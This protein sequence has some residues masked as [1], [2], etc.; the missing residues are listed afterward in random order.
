MPEHTPPKQGPA[1]EDVSMDRNTIKQDFAQRLYKE[2]TNKGWTQAQLARYSGLNR[3]AISTYIRARSL[4]T[5]LSLSKIA[6]TLGCSPKDLLPSH[7]EVVVENPKK[8]RSARLEITEIEGEE[9][10]MHLRC[11]L[12]LEKDLAIKVFMLLSEAEE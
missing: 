12:K 9:G 7:Y 8:E 11:N 5:A 3:D 1:I 6:K 10:Y 4:P 2:I